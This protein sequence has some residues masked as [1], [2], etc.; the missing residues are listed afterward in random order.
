MGVS[1]NVLTA[2]DQKD[3]E[4]VLCEPLK[5]R[6]HTPEPWATVTQTTGASR[7]GAPRGGCLAGGPRK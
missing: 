2:E 6:G 5:Q 7:R 4:T 3:G 1:V